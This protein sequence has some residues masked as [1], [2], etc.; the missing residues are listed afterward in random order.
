[1]VTQDLY[2]FPGFKGQFSKITPGFAVAEKLSFSLVVEA[3]RQALPH[4]DVNGEVQEDI[5][6]VADGGKENNNK[7][8]DKFLPGREFHRLTKLVALKDIQFP[9]RRLRRYIRS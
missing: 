8:V 5:M 7:E 3:I 4:M 1:L 2:I 6:L 9:I